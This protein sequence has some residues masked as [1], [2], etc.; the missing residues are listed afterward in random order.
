MQQEFISNFNQYGKTVVDSAKELTAIN[1][2]LV[3]KLLASQ[4]SL[5]KIFV[6]G[7][8]KQLAVIGAVESPADLASKEAALIEEV[9]GKI[10]DATQTSVKIVQEA[11]TEFKSWFEN[12]IGVADKAVKEA[13]SPVV[14]SKPA[15][16]KTAT[17]KKASAKKAS[18]TKKTAT[19]NKTTATK[20]T[21]VKTPTGKKAA[22]VKKLSGPIN[23]TKPLTKTTAKVTATDK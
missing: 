19:P 3:N 4:L 10:T 7:T 1:N 12:G 6:E 5:A 16:K 20:S 11:N 17:V 8:E 14:Q 9:A 21:V 18:A 23:K 15:A 2:R 22:V 13:A